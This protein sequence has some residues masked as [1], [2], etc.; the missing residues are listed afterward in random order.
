LIGGLPVAGRL[1]IDPWNGRVR[2]PLTFRSRG[3]IHRRRLGVLDGA[4]GVTQRIAQ[5]LEIVG[6]GRLGAGTIR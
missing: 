4:G 1:R 2:P 3:T 5:T 6:S